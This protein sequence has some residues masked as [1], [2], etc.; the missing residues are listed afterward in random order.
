MGGDIF[1]KC[2]DVEV[3]SQSLR[4]QHQTAGVLRGI[5]PD[6]P[7]C[8]LL[9][10]A[11]GGLA[12]TLRVL[13]EVFQRWSIAPPAAQSRNSLT[14]GSFVHITQKRPKRSASLSFILRANASGV[15]Q[16]QLMLTICAL[17]NQ[18]TLMR[19]ITLPMRLF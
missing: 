16:R 15:T 14:K 6:G 12:G 13:V 10:T 18:G 9:R 1:R 5:P 7:A 3:Q 17:P 11:G 19:E 4:L 2:S 8:Q